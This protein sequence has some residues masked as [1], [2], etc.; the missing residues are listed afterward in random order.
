MVIIIKQV[1]YF[2][3]LRKSTLSHTLS[4]IAVLV[5]RYACMPA[6]KVREPDQELA[7]DRERE[8]GGDLETKKAM[9]NERECLL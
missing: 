5:Y 8:G 3:L 7:E 6:H 1:K 4:F 2:P 9:K